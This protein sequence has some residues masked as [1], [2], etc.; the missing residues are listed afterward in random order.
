MEFGRGIR[1]RQGGGGTVR[2]VLW[3]GESVCVATR[4]IGR[5]RLK[6]GLDL[7]GILNDKLQMFLG[8]SVKVK[9]KTN[10]EHK[11]MM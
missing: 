11:I 3:A 8:K 6:L 4:G 9:R 10:L 1:E 7:F 5:V 2:G